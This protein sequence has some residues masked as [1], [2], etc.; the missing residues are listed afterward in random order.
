[1]SEKIIP[2]PL[3]PYCGQHDVAFYLVS[4]YNHN[5]QGCGFLRCGHCGNPVVAIFTSHISEERK[6]EFAQILRYYPEPQS[7]DA[8]PFTPPKIA[9]D[10]EEAKFNL[11]HGKYKAACIMAGS[12]IETACVQFGETGRNGLADK[13]NKLQAKGVITQSLADWAREIRAIRVNA[14]HEAEREA[15]ITRE[16]AEQAVYFAE[17]LFRY[18]YTLPG[19][20]EE[21]RKKA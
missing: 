10:F 13:I 8:P 12:A 5:H 20:I 1:M 14:A 4:A 9:S 17:M 3:C 21:R 18:L 6:A 2:F 7:E 16:D 11:I 19:M 15:E